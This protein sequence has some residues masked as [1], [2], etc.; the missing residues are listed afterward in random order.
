MRADVITS[1]GRCLRRAVPQS[2]VGA[3]PA[4]LSYQ[5]GAGIVDNPVEDF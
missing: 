3:P 5:F 4:E 2:A 1:P